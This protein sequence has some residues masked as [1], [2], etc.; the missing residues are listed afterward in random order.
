MSQ[1]NVKSAG[2]TALKSEKFKRMHIIGDIWPCM[3]YTT[4][5]GN[6]RMI[7]ELLV[8]VNNT[9][10][11]RWMSRYHIV[12]DDMVQKHF[13]SGWASSQQ[14]SATC[15]SYLNDIDSTMGFQANVSSVIFLV[16]CR[17]LYRAVLVSWCTALIRL[18]GEFVVNLCDLFSLISQGL[19][20]TLGQTYAYQW[21]RYIM[22]FGSHFLL[23]ML[24]P[25][26]IIKYNYL[27]VLST[28][29]ERSRGVSKWLSGILAESVFKI[30]LVISIVFLIFATYGFK[31]VQ[32]HI[33]LLHFCFFVAML[34][35]PGGF[36]ISNKP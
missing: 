4:T 30:K 10:T 8:T 3:L 29:S 21:A 16:Q 34:W 36:E 32:S 24:L 15:G 9:S 25:S 1:A 26:I 17:E 19:S 23:S 6:A 20:M 11:E 5:D 22:D 31:C 12:C 28:C 18:Y 33:A 14:W 35:V 2:M 7:V 27:Q 13:Y